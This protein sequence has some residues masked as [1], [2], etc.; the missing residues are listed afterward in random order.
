MNALD[1]FLTTR[2][3]AL[4]SFLVQA[5]VKTKD[6]PY[7]AETISKCKCTQHKNVLNQHTTRIQ[8]FQYSL[9]ILSDFH[10]SVQKLHVCVCVCVC[11]WYVCACVCVFVCVWCVCTCVCGMRVYVCMVCVCVKM[12]CKREIT[13]FTYPTMSLLKSYTQHHYSTTHTIG[14]HAQYMRK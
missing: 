13:P 12:F 4:A 9:C 8:L 11:V 3:N 5:Q 7:K 14:M 1:S 2:T 6:E 10:N